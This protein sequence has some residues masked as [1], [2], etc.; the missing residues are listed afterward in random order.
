MADIGDRATVN[1]I[2]STLNALCGIP[3]NLLILKFFTKDGF[4]EIS[5]HHLCIVHLA[6]ADLIAC[7]FGEIWDVYQYFNYNVIENMPGTMKWIFNV[8]YFIMFL[9]MSAS[10]GILLVMAYDRYSKITRPLQIDENPKRKVNLM[11]AAFYILA[12]FGILPTDLFIKDRNLETVVNSITYSIGVLSLV[13]APIFGNVWFYLKVKKYLRITA[14]EGNMNVTQQQH[15]QRLRNEVAVQTLRWLTIFMLICVA[16][17][18]IFISVV[19]ATLVVEKKSVR[20]GLTMDS[21]TIKVL[22]L[23]S[24]NLIYINNAVN[25][26]VYYK[27]IR[28]FRT[29]IKRLF[30]FH[31]RRAN[32]AEQ[33]ESRL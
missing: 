21:L 26:F 31:R 23:I 12:I 1:M 3:G 24:N 25:V 32:S 14:A 20:N 5:S 18:K 27:F 7:L 9:G 4:R 10:G 13:V 8:V 33:R 19:W 16:G 6:I 17:P 29:W 2:C 11:T 30:G 28:E 22:I 15:R